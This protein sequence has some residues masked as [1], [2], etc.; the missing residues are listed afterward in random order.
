MIDKENGRPIYQQIRER[1]LNII[2]TNELLE[3]HQLPT[4]A[5]LCEELG[6]SRTSV[7]KA[8]SGL[9][10]RGYLSR[11]PGKG[12]FV[13][14]RATFRNTPALGD[15]TIAFVEN[16]HLYDTKFYSNHVWQTL[17]R[18]LQSELG[19]RGYGQFISQMLPNR[20]DENRPLINRLASRAN[21]IVLAEL[22]DPVLAEH[23]SIA[24]SAGTILVEPSVNVDGIDSI[25]FYNKG[26]GR[27]ACSY[28]VGLGHERIAFIGGP[29][30]RRPARHRKRG[31]L[32]RAREIGLPG[33]A[34]Q[35]MVGDWSVE[36]GYRAMQALLDGG[37][38]FSGLFCAN[39]FMALGAI[40]AALERGVRIPDDL[41]VLG[42]DDALPERT[43]P[44]G[45]STFR[46][47]LDHILE[48]LV[49]RIE[50][51]VAGTS[52]PVMH[53]SFEATL[54]ERGSCSP[55]HR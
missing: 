29:E 21:V 32:G 55:H 36:S 26:I 15:A 12:T 2:H 35:V 22:I 30:E 4:E 43:L 14:S 24:G 50:K 9:V 5:E 52:A 28:L 27:K 48:V 40:N 54:E 25:S 38:P 23:L 31:F 42:V 45:L 8:I 3:G 17:M 37:Q 1:L 51:L 7:R 20:G 46:F 47:P 11:I 33:G 16:E 19:R 53:V 13:L 18:K 41:S 49:E 39:D 34:L 10:E 44:F 6:V